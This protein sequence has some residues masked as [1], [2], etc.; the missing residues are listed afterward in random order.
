MAWDT[1]HCERD[2]DWVL[3]DHS[4]V[5]IIFDAKVIKENYDVLYAELSELAKRTLG[6]DL[7]KVQLPL[8]LKSNYV[9]AICLLTGEEEVLIPIKSVVEVGAHLELQSHHIQ[10][11]HDFV[12]DRLAH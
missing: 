4:W 12:A 1:T 5:L 6:D 10:R 2:I 7:L 11:F 3:Q 9:T 8:V